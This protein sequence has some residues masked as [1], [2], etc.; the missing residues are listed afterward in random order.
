VNGNCLMEVLLKSNNVQRLV[1]KVGFV[2]ITKLSSALL[3]VRM[4]EVFET[5]CCGR[6]E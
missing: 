5:E 1:R 2:E 6:R 3:G 4:C